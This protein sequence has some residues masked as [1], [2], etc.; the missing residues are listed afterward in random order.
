MRDIDS[1]LFLIQGVEAI[2]NTC[3]M[4]R[5]VEI[6]LFSLFDSVNET[7]SET[8]FDSLCEIYSVSLFDS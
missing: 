5:S 1:D 6:K 7:I 3:R 2:L 4:I 8:L